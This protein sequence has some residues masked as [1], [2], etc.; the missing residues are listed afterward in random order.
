V[1]IRDFAP[2]WLEGLDVDPSTKESVVHKFNKHF[3]P[4]LGGYE[5]GVC[6]PGHLRTWLQKCTLG[7][8]AKAVL[9]GYV[10]QMFDAAVDDGMRRD[11][12]CKAKSVKRPTAPRNVILP[13]DADQVQGIE[14]ALH[15]RYRAMVPVGGGCGL[16]QGEIF[17]LSPEDR[18]DDERMLEIRRQ[19]KIVGG[20]LVFAPP[21]HDSYRK[22]PLPGFVAEA[23]DVRAHR[24]PFLAPR[25]GLGL[26]RRKPQ[27]HLIDLAHRHGAESTE[28]FEQFAKIGI[29]VNL[30]QVDA[31]I[32]FD[33]A[34]GN[35]RNASHFYWDIAMW[36][37]NPTSPVPASYFAQWR[38]GENR[39]NIAQE[40]NGWSGQN[41]QR[42]VNEEFDEIVAEARSVDDEEERWAMYHEANRIQIEDGAAIYIYN[43]WNYG[44]MKPWVDN[45][46]MNSEGDFV[47]SW[48]IFIREYDHYR[49][50]E[51]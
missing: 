20:K 51:H 3:L 15:P 32:F 24:A 47:P 6:K 9:F 11:N 43:P 45:L 19:V 7:E 26:A 28:A 50:L 29:K 34:A 8:A 39:E 44:L 48:N 18:L 30:D 16:R 36:T 31:G 17:G 22:T 4:Q 42:W 21:K 5:V 12:P 25:V 10:Q 35:D 49:I 46:P 40:S 27:A 23:L 41:V 37:N 14:A 13:W 33:S 2:G 38:A 1:L